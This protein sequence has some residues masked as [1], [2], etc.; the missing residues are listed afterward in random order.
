MTLSVSVLAPLAVM[1]ALPIFAQVSPGPLSQAH[2]DLEGTTQCLSC[3]VSGASMDERCTDCHLEIDFQVRE[4]RG[5]HG[6][7]TKTDC[8]FCHPEHAGRDFELIKWEEGSPDRFDHRRTGW[9]LEGKH[10]VLRCEQCHKPEFQNGSVTQLL[11]RRSVTKSWLGLERDCLSCHRDY[12]QGTMKADCLSCHVAEGWKPASRFDH[13]ET[14]F[15]LTGKHVDTPCAKCHLVPGRAELRNAQGEAVPR[16][17]PVAFDECSACHKDVHGGQL[18]PQCSTCHVTDGFKIVERGKFDHSKTLYALIG[19]HLAVECAECHDPQRAWG[20]KPR[21]D[22]CDAC[23]RDP[24][25]GKATLAGRVVDCAECHDVNGFKPSTYTVAQHREANYPLEG[26]HQTVACDA[27]HRKEPPVT[28]SA[29]LGEARVLIR[30]AYEHCRDCHRDLHGGQLAGRQDQG[31]CETCHHV[32]NWKPSTFTVERHAETEFA[33]AG[34]HAA[35]E[36]AACHGPERPGLPP[37]PGPETLGEARVALT[38]IDQAC[39]TCHYDPHD[40]RFEPQGVRPIAEGCRGCHGARAFVPSSVDREVHGRFAYPLQGAHRAVPCALC[41]EELKKA[42]A[43]VRLLR[44]DGPSRS[45]AFEAKHERCESCHTSPHQD[46]FS[47]RGDGGECGGCHLVEGWRPAD[48]FD[49]EQD[50]EFS[51]KGGHQK[52]ACERCHGMTPD[53]EGRPFVVYR[54]T[55][56]ECLDCHGRAAIR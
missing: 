1:A 28:S 36:C 18:G 34:R 32:E 44:V 10:A 11:K 45:L 50:A 38:T 21:H 17:K 53:S 3:H 20:Q 12:H 30:S 42:P 40:S 39:R 25:V 35:I 4:G 5:L 13:A 9:S 56:K 33:L 6:Q 46:Q 24:H 16:Y 7:E 2:A 29:S 26:R 51:L 49:H 52:V 15:P 43:T 19:K 8:V 23:H 55:K 41:H 27:C 54:P 47:H 48:R 37:L 31:A 22:T 14:V